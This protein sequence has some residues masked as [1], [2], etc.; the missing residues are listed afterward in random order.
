[1]TI[2][3]REAFAARLNEARLARHLS[4]SAVARLIDVPKATAQGW[5]N[6][7][8][9][10]QLALRPKYL[11]LV[12]ELGLTDEL[13]DGLWLNGWAEIEPRLH[14][15]LSPYLGLRQ[16]GTAD[17]EYYCGRSAEARRLAAAV[18]AL[19]D[20]AGHGIVALVG[21]SG[22][23]KSSLLAAGIAGRECV[24][25]ELA[26]WVVRFIGPDQ[27]EDD[28]TDADL[29]IF[30]QLDH[31]LA[32][33]EDE[34][35]AV[36]SRLE[37]LAASRVVLV[38]LRSDAFAAAEAQ[39]VFVEALS[40]P[41]LVA[42]LTRAELREVIV[43]PAELAGVDVDEDLV[44]VLLNDVA[45]GSQDAGVSL[46]VLPLMSNALLVTWMAGAGERMSLADYRKE[47][48][49][50]GT[51]ENLAEQVYSELDGD[52]QA[53]TQ[54]LFLRLISVTEDAVVPRALLLSELDADSR[55]V[56]DSFVA[57]RM[58]T[59][60]DRQV[61]ISHE[62]LLRHWSR[63][64]DWVQEHRAELDSL[65]KL[66]RAAELWRDTEQDPNVLIPVQRLPMFTEW[67]DDP[68]RQVLL[69]ATERDFLA[70]SE[71][72]FASALDQERRMSTRLRRDRAMALGL[73]VATTAAALVAGVS[74][75][76][77]ESFRSEAVSSRNEAESRQVAVAAR[78]LRAK[79]PNLGAQLALVA[80]QLA[81]TQ[82][83][84]S[85]VMD[86]ASIDV[87]LR[88]LGKPAATLAVS[89]DGNLV[90]RAD[91]AGSVT[92]WRGTELT[93]DSGATFMADPAGGALT[94]VA[95]TQAGGR[96]VLAVA[97]SSV[98]S[99]WDVTD[100]PARLADLT[101]SGGT[102][103]A[104]NAAGSRV[105]FGDAKGGATVYDITAPERPRQVAS[106][107]PA[108]ADV[109]TYSVA[110]GAD[111]LYVAGVR[112][113]VARW[114]LSATPV[115]LAPLPVTVAGPSGR[116]PVRAQALA[117]SPDGS[118]LAAGLA[119]NEV[120]RWR[121]GAG[122]TTLPEAPLTAFADIINGVVFSQDSASIAVA[123]A[124]QVVAVFSAADGSL[125]RRM[126][127]R[128]LQTS[129]GFSASGRPVSTGNDGALLVWPVTSPLW[130]RT[131]AVIYNLSA[132]GTDWLAGGSSTD[133]I[134]LWH[135]GDPARRM[136]TP[137]P[138]RLASDDYQVGAVAVAPS[139]RYLLGSSMRGQVL[140][141]PLTAS[142]T[143]TGRAV[144]S[145]AGASIIFTAVSPDSTMVAAMSQRASQVVLFRADADGALTRLAS[146]RVNVPQL[147]GFSADGTLLAIA[148]VDNRVTLWSTRDPAHPV[149]VGA[150]GGLGGVPTTLDMAPGSR[151]IAIGESS[152]RVSVW[153]ISDPAR[154]SEQRSWTDA[155]SDI[156]SLDF[157]SDEHRLIG[158][159][160]DDVVW[161]WRLD[162]PA[163]QA[164]FALN[165]EIGRPWDVRFLADGDRFAGSG[166]LGAVRVWHG[167][168]ASAAQDLCSR[169]GDPLTAEEWRRYLP[170]IEPRKIC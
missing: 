59:V 64:A 143:G 26:G 9:L 53:L 105:A 65:A 32:L 112:G 152:G 96:T 106:V 19:H 132:E 158:T 86:A 149:Q 133:G 45:P 139:G 43:R 165:G 81:D 47:G 82:E 33:P 157:S 30:D 48:G 13:P 41:V 115:E 70:A 76:R 136:P 60:D 36:V 69:G 155:S 54:R 99:L 146:V 2:P 51:V 84:R 5:L 61:R 16:F 31:A 80:N 141:W 109:Q 153:D 88:W 114:R 108:A 156:Y 46:D 35:R 12:D 28:V 147:V 95:L 87:P 77:G 34:R 25:G 14:Q 85:A 135:L 140:S 78:S 15:G 123:S 17:V 103:V 75:A 142:G 52:S 119:G 166:D 98:R 102:A 110:L 73:A 164:D 100:A 124:D 121:I 39:P 144:D 169:I 71:Q 159:S 151:R 8:R 162:S 101:P 130:K 56:V 128:S 168:A 55:R 40:R 113:E 131:G 93:S 126:D 127:T 117:V 1:M 170:G 83:A 49:V 118:Q 91:G 167:T 58:L 67:L 4:I 160:G 18:R 27:L 3:A 125:Q 134:A 92:L 29:L 66:R 116:L 44:H 111:T 50:A 104:F 62:A 57:A 137:V 72:H 120:A 94:S 6:G 38:G 20:S 10:P 148:E 68:D 21:P 7:T 24:D 22:C 37:R 79:A 145:G 42:P 122:G 23:G 11:K 150:V 107:R 74:Y 97:G 90:A 161:G 138:P 63:L 163:T 129:V 154:P 89:P